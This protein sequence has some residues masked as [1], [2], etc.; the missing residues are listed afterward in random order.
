MMSL[1]ELIAQPENTSLDIRTFQAEDIS[2]DERAESSG[3][4][5]E[6]LVLPL[7]RG[8]C[9]EAGNRRQGK[10]ELPTEAAREEMTKER[11]ERLER[12]AYEKGFEQG[13][14][15]GIALEKRQ[16]EE[17]AKEMETLFLGLQ[18]LKSKVLFETEAQVLKLSMMIA[19]KIIRE[20]VKTDRGIIERTITSALKFIVDRSRLQ[21][22]LNPEDLEEVRKLLPELACLSK[23]GP[24]ELV[25]DRSIEAGGC[26][27]ETGFG[28]I[29]ATIEDQLDELGQEIEKTFHAH[30]GSRP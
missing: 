8:D 18:N 28:I 9:L 29:N 4:D 6:A 14:R 1:S 3:N 24:F 26:V 16:M 22:R 17:K 5:K 7:S 2:P 12:E 30:S 25:E 27:L 21:V 10:R 19:R 13:Q 11:L 15:D 23:G 20:E